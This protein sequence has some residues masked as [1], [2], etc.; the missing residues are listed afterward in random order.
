MADCPVVFTGC[1]CRRSA[2]AAFVLGGAGWAAAHASTFLGGHSFGAMIADALASHALPWPPL[3][4]WLVVV[5]ASLYGLLTGI[6]PALEEGDDAPTWMASLASIGGGI[7]A[8]AFFGQWPGLL[9]SSVN[10][11][12][13]AAIS[14][15]AANV[16][17]SLAARGY[18]AGYVAGLGRAGVVPPQFDL[19]QWQEVIDRQAVAIAGLTAERDRLAYDLARVGPPARELQEVLRWPDVRKAVLKVLHR[20]SHPGVGEVEARDYDRRF[21]KASAIYE[22]LRD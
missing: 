1:P 13:V 7:A 9:W 21:Q 16:A 19:G 12:A 11:L 2:K 4:G 14:F 18:E 3:A 15:G 20:D 10:G 5:V 17:L 8:L 6:M 22:R